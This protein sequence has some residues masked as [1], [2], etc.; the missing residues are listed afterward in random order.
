MTTGQS[1]FCQIY[2]VMEIFITERLQ[3]FDNNKILNIRNPG[4]KKADSAVY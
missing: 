2:Q 4:F 1:H 3:F